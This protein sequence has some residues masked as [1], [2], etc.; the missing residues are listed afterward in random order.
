[1]N[2]T[3]CWIQAHKDKFLATE[4][5]LKNDFEKVESE[6]RGLKENSTMTSWLEIRK[7]KHFVEKIKC[8]INDIVGELGGPIC[9]P[10]P[11][12]EF[13]TNENT[14]K[15]NFEEGFNNQQLLKQKEIRMALPFL[16][17]RFGID[18][19]ILEQMQ[20]YDQE[21]NERLYFPSTICA[22]VL[23]NHCCTRIVR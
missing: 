5:N 23:S 3:Q 15:F 11:S 8:N 18:D 9:P 13:P 19:A 16:L 10:S 2:K 21:E 20:R 17:S 7:Q 6:S 4:Q 12:L 14:C 1:V 22:P